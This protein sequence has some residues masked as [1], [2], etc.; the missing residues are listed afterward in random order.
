[1]GT[2][3]SYG[4]SGGSKPLIPSWLSD[5]GD[6]GGAANPLPGVLPSTDGV[7]APAATSLPPVPPAGDPR[8]YTS[9]RNNF[10]RF[11]S[12]GGSDREKSRARAIAIRVELLWREPQ[13]GK[14]DGRI[15]QVDGAA[16]RRP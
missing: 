8:R 6:G 7:G 13:C 9:A 4:G 3:N 2:S 11:V 12:S 14:E 10:T 15:A 16:G 1:M 5:G